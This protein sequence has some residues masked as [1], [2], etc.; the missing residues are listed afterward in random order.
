MLVLFP[1][2]DLYVQPLY[3]ALDFSTRLILCVTNKVR[4]A[5]TYKSTG[6][7]RMTLEEE[8]P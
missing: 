3:N 2:S 7:Y 6:V 4:F 1:L 5:L 8:L